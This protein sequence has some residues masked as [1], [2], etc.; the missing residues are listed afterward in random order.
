MGITKF[1]LGLSVL[2]KRFMNAF[3]LLT[4]FIVSSDCERRGE[5][6]IPE[7][8]YADYRFPVDVILTADNLT[9]GHFTP[10]D[11]FQLSEHSIDFE[12]R[13]VGTYNH[14]GESPGLYGWLRRTLSDSTGFFSNEFTDEDY[15]FLY[16]DPRRCYASVPGGD[17]LA[18]G[19]LGRPNYL[20]PVFG[21]PGSG[22]SIV[23]VCSAYY[24]SLDDSTCQVPWAITAADTIHVTEIWYRYRIYD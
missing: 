17:T 21:G 8:K 13:I 14:S 16:V 15:T 5:Y 22:Y 3:F 4:I 1:L 7:P 18:I 9:W 19:I 20:L 2:G 23:I 10:K 11:Y 12:V 6:V 24:P